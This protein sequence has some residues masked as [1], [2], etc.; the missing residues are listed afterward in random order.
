MKFKD[1]H[2]D[3]QNYTSEKYYYDHLPQEFFNTLQ[4]LITSAA[5]NSEFPNGTLRQACDIIANNI[6]TK[7]TTNSGWSWLVEDLDYYVRQLRSKKLNKILDTIAAL[8]KETEI[9]IENL[10]EELDDISFGF[11]LEWDRWD[12]YKWV[13]VEGTESSVEAIEEAL[14]EVSGEQTNVLEHLIQ[15]KKQITELSSSRARKDALRD[16]ITALESQLKYYS[17]TKKI[18]DSIAEIRNEYDV[19]R[20]IIGDAKLIWDRIHDQTPDVRHGSQINSELSEAEAL[21]WIDR[22]MALIKFLARE[23]EG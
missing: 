8:V 23:I 19:P 5:T 11:I 17:G 12:G 18:E 21:Y 22:I 7:P 2:P 20:K 14:E 4:G 15:A 13:Q 9:D 6:P 10:N 1:K 16:C 3:Y